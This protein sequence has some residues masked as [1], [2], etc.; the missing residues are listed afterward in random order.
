MGMHNS[1][2][3][4]RRTSLSCLFSGLMLVVTMSWCATPQRSQN[5][6]PVSDA[7][8]LVA[9]GYDF[10]ASQRGETPAQQ[11]IMAIK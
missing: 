6:Y 4:L 11:R 3:G 10:L 1:A 2:L 5:L 7:D 8:G 9:T